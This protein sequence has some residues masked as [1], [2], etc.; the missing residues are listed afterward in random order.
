MVRVRW[1]AEVEAEAAQRFGR[2]KSRTERFLDVYTVPIVIALI[3]LMAV[4]AFA[5][6]GA[7]RAFCC[8]GSA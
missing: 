7:Q 2:M 5:W 3:A 6:G 8:P 4:A 1:T